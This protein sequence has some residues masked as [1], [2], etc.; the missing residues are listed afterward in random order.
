MRNDML[1]G[2]SEPHPV[3]QPLG[4]SAL[5]GPPIDQHIVC[6]LGVG[7]GLGLA[8]AQLFA[9]QGYTTAILSRNKQRL[10][11]WAVELDQTIQKVRGRRGETPQS[12]AFACDV[13]SDD[14][15]REA[16]SS[17]QKAWPDKKMGTAI[18]NA[19][20]RKRGPFLDQRP[21]QIKE[22]VQASVF[23]GITFMQ[24]IIRAMSSKGNQGGTIIVTGATSSTRGREGFAAFA[25]SK[26]GLRAACQ[27]VAKE[28]GPK[29]IHISHVV[30]D[31]LIESQQA[32]DH[33]GLDKG[34]RFPDGS[35]LRPEEMCKAWLFL[36]SQHRSA[37]TFEMD[38]R[39]A[40]EH[41]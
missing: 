1:A 15:I 22:V 31:G 33:L 3:V 10:D 39:P 7:P 23:A 2:T 27:S 12:L 24:T 14:S 34:T 16:I 25:A 30:V 40:K 38:L 36:A 26:S 32:I 8:I 18:Y 20:V 17:I 28:Y 37:W 6:I 29:N 21:E 5:H 4:T 13:L 19:S 35:A 9:G 41:F 11:G